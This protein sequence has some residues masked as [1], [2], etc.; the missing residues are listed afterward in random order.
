M[1]RTARSRSALFVAVCAF[2]FFFAATPRDASADDVHK[3]L[4]DFGRSGQYTLYIS[5]KVQKKARIFHSRRAGAFLILDSDFGKPWLVLPRQRKVATVPADALVDPKAKTINLKADAKLEELGSVRIQGRDFLIKVEGLVAR[6]R[7]QAYAIGPLNAE[8]L[9]LHS[10]EYERGVQRYRPRSSD[11]QALVDCATPTEV[12][13]FFGTWCPTCKR[14]LPRILHV[15]RAIQGS[16]IKITYYGLPKSRGGVR[17][18][19]EARRNGVTRVPTGVIYA[20]GRRVG[21]INSRGLS[22]PENALC[23]ALTRAR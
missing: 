10:P 5:Q 4:R 8:E 16:S 18:D 15:D 6:M 13:I 23:G 14:L 11:V 21:T 3:S 7:P 20:N 2:A 12:I 19:P 17:S 22:R 1:G 9:L